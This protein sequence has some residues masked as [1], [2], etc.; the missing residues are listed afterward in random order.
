MRRTDWGFFVFHHRKVV[1]ALLLCTAMAPLSRGQASADAVA[2][3][4]R[5]LAAQMAQL[6]QELT[7]SRK[8]SADLQRQ[9]EEMR[10]QLQALRGTPAG[11]AAS[12]VLTPEQL[13]E[14]HELLAAKVDDQYQ[15]KV[16]SSSKYRVKLSGL[17]LFS[18][19]L[20]TGEVNNLDLPSYALPRP[21]GDTNGALSAT[22][23]QSILG[24]EL[25]GPKLMG[26]RT[27]GDIHADFFGGMP[28]VPDG[29]TTGFMR[30]RTARLGLDWKN[31]TVEVGQ[32][33][34][35]FSPLTPSSLIST[36]Y[37]A[38]WNAGN[39]WTWTPQ[40]NVTHRFRKPDATRFIL[41]YGVLNALTG[42]LPSAEYDR[43]PS[44]GERNR[45]P[46]TA[47]RLGTERTTS[48]GKASA[49]AGFYY[50]RQ[51]W[52]FNRRVDS[53]AATADWELPFHRY[54]TF[55]GELYRGR[56]IGGLGGGIGRSVL[57]TG[58]LNLMSTR[59]LPL[60]SGG[61]WAQLKFKPAQ[62]WEFNAVYGGDFP[63][64]GSMP[65]FAAVYGSEELKPRRNAT[66]MANIMYQP[67]NN[68]IFSIE[69]RRLWT[70][71][72]DETQ[73]RANHIGIGAGIFF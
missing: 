18:A 5:E 38:L 51:N 32:E 45:T 48:H 9:V 40:V 31:T 14:E 34:P 3:Q 56:A 41:Q 16:E 72:F 33:S 13:T 59:I 8:E 65:K 44:A 42:E 61:G 36:A 67:R 7:D 2:A 64:Q 73:H 71:P 25:D 68:L 6:R 62:R 70:S 21:A 49:G 50:A 58:A 20:N 69:Y 53:W 55:S 19:G 37:P 54:F 15:T 52:G 30:L 39:L 22:V 17:V 63:M 47:V 24:L 66:G 46:A 12:T 29:V 27:R 23:R 43:G 1:A 10:Q 28:G 4:L 60:Q 35:F 11:V 57:T 26:A